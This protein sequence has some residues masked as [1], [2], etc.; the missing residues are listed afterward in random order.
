MTSKNAAGWA[1]F[2]GMLLEK[3]PVPP[4]V[5]VVLVLQAASGVVRLVE[6]STEYVPPAVPPEPVR[7][8]LPPAYETGLTVRLLPLE[9]MVSTPVAGLNVPLPAGR[10]VTELKLPEPGLAELNNV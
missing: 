10:M 2:T 1:G 8:R 9:V 5:P 3:L 6:V 4:N 7:I